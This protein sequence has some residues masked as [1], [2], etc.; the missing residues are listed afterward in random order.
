MFNNSLMNKNISL[1]WIN[2]V[3]PTEYNI[4][5]EGYSNASIFII[6]PLERGFGL[7]IGNC[8]R[9][10]MLSSLYGSSICSVRIGEVEHEY[11]SPSYVLE[12]IIDIH[13]NLKLVIF[14]G[15][16]GFESK[17]F[18]LPVR[19]K[20]QVTAAMI[21]LTD[22]FEVVNPDL[23]IC[24]ITQDI[25]LDIELVVISGKGYVASDCHREFNYG[26]NFI[27][28]DS[29]FSPVK[30]CFFDIFA[31]RIGFKDEYDKLK[32]FIETNGSIS[33]ETVLK[34][35]SRIMQEQL[36]VFISFSEIK[37]VEKPKKDILPFDKNL[38][39][40]VDDLEL[41][42]RSQNCLNVVQTKESIV[43]PQDLLEGTEPSH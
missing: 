35:S 15:L 5:R 9:R 13:L 18:I 10:I 31:S 12:D 7:T 36:Q 22:G 4:K 25:K 20:G 1:N 27:N 8:L 38:L 24:N 23:V 16:L 39:K 17:K 32:F 40:K 3:L 11:Y 26:E 28:I 41:S 37:E 33:P 19:S 2:L 29:I 14:K 34:L 21:K 43:L 6:E 42:V 30:R